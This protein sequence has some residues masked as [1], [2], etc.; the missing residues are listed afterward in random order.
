MLLLVFLKDTRMQG[1]ISPHILFACAILLVACF[2]HNIKHFLPELKTYM[3]TVGLLCFTFGTYVK[4]FMHFVA[5][6]AV[7]FSAAIF[8]LHKKRNSFG[9]IMT[10]QPSNINVLQYDPLKYPIPSNKF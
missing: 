5:I 9:N 4:N 10:P 7:L 2:Y 1:F 6:C 3:I 8:Y